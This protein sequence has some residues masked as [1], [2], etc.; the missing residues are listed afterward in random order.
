MTDDQT[1][2]EGAVRDVDDAIDALDAID[3]SSTAKTI[4]IVLLTAAR[5]LIRTVED[6]HEESEDRP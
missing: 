2:I 5:L 3:H 4:A 6:R 1:R